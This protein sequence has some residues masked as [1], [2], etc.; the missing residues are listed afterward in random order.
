MDN[1][2]KSELIGFLTLNEDKEIRAKWLKE[3]HPDATVKKQ[4]DGSTIFEDKTIK[5]IIEG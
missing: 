1:K 2:E 4:A 5:F 3:N